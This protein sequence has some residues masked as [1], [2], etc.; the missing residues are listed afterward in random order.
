MDTKNSPI[1]GKIYTT[2]PNLYIL[3]EYERF[4]HGEPKLVPLVDDKEEEPDFTGSIWDWIVPSKKK[5]IPKGL[6]YEVCFKAVIKVDGVI[7]PLTRSSYSQLGETINSFIPLR[8][9]YGKK[10]GDIVELNVNDHKIEVECYQR[11]FH[12]CIEKQDNNKYIY[13][14]EDMMEILSKYT[15]GFKYNDDFEQCPKQYQECLFV[16]NYFNYVKSIGRSVGDFG[17]IF[18]DRNQPGPIQS[19]HKSEQRTC[20]YDERN[21]CTY[22]SGGPRIPYFDPVTGDKLDLIFGV[23]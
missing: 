2:T 11:A 21:T 9:F 6:R 19:T 14:F 17:L 3:N 22:S 8:L 5:V 1:R 20:C 18:R 7:W 15:N 13:N 16:T 12:C 10:E 23:E 4:S